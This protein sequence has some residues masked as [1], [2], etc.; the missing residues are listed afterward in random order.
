ML[1]LVVNPLHPDPAALES[2]PIPSD[3]LTQVLWPQWAP[4]V[5]GF[6]IL[7]PAVRFAICAGDCA[8]RGRGCWQVGLFLVH[9]LDPLALHAPSALDDVADEDLCYCAHADDDVLGDGLGDGR[10]DKLSERLAHCVQS[11]S[12]KIQGSLPS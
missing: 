11:V 8:G 1:L 12:Q 4:P 9:P 5:V 7:P 3:S 2:L 6:D 10:V